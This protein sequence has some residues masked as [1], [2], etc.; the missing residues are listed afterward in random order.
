M[1]LLSS[2]FVLRGQLLPERDS[3]TCWVIVSA[4]VSWYR[5]TCFSTALKSIA[6][7]RKATKNE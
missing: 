5:S 2:D 7:D 4:C 3:R 6:T 1:R